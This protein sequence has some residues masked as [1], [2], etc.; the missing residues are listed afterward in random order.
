M[1]PVQ[2]SRR[3]FTMSGMIEAVIVAVVEKKTG[4]IVDS[5]C[6]SGT[7]Q[8][9]QNKLAEEQF[10]DFAKTY[11]S[12]WNEYTAEDVDACVEDGVIESGTNIIQITHP[13]TALVCPT[14]MPKD[15]DQPEFDPIKNGTIFIVG[16]TG[17]Q[18]EDKLHLVCQATE[19]G[20]LYQDIYPN[21]KYDE[22]GSRMTLKGAKT[23]AKKLGCHSPRVI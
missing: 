20:D 1:S 19:D 16:P 15:E 13:E 4:M 21:D 14:G 11:L 8:K 5:A 10:K 17:N 18:E 6:F 23:L 2:K 7:D 12:N 3:E 22:V 9:E